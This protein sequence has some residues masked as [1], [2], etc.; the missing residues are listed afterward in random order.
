MP[1]W[2]VYNGD[3]SLR[4]RLCKNHIFIYILCVT[5]LEKRWL[6]HVHCG[7]RERWW[8]QCDALSN[9][10]LGKLG[11][12]HL[13]YYITLTC[14]TYL[15]SDAHQVHP[16]MVAIFPKQNN[17]SWYTTKVVQECYKE[18]DKEFKVLTSRCLQ[19]PISQSYCAYVGCAGKN[20]CS[21]WRPMAYRA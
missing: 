1:L 5:C 7:K 9:L 10:L 4:T 2:C 6:L 17:T 18:D 8:G 12:W 20:K 14:T 19:F 21:P 15:N 13:L 3:V 11:S 16:F